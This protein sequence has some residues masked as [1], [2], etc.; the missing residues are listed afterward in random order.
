MNHALILPLLLPLFMGALLLFAHRANKSTKRVL[1]LAATWTLVPIAIWLVLLADDGQLRI[2]ALGSW[3]PPFGII[4]MLD[5]LSALMLLVTAVLAGFAA[6]YACRGDD[7]RGPNFHAL[8]QFQLL[9]ING[10]FLTGDLFNLFVFF[11]ILL[12]SSY[13]L[14]LHGHG[15]RRVRSGMH[16][17][18]LNLLGSSLFLIGVSMLYGL[19]GTLNM[20]DMAARVSAADPADAPLLAAAGYL[21]LVVFALKGAILPLYFWLPR[22]YASATAPVAALFAIM[23]KVGLYAIIRVFTLVFGSEAGELSGMVDVW[24]WPLALLTLGAAVIGALAARSLQVLLAYLVVVS[25]GTLLAG[26]ALGS[27]AGLAAALYYLVHSTLVAGG[28]FLLA[29]L[30]ARQRGDLGTDL[31]SAPAL[32]Q[33]LLLGTLF[34]MG[35]ISVAGLPPFS[36]FLG[37]VMLLR[38]IELGADAI[39]LWA[40]VLV[41]GL[42]MLISL[43]RAGSLVFWRPSAEAVGQPADAIRVLATVG[44]LLGSVMLV[45]AAGPLQAF[46]QATAAQLLDVAPYLQILQGGA[47]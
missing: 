18:V 28:L 30:I 14:L 37:K 5:R 17:V 6:L 40:V 31:I 26:I 12:I 34:F 8:Y 9:G 15:Q 7:E 36:G 20:V 43:S 19:L 22:A 41:G 29:D 23:T 16:Y 32:R 21:L 27:E 33:P 47:A 3:Q 1:S 4:L 2:Y 11:E 24:L 42:G 39:A 46:V 44:L 13:A 10:A 25:V 35:A 38:A 45:V